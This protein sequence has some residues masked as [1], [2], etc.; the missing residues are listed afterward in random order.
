[1]EQDLAA[2]RADRSAL[3]GHIDA[4]WMQVGGNPSLLE[5]EYGALKSKLDE[6]TGQRSVVAADLLTL[7]GILDQGGALV[8]PEEQA[9]LNEQDQLS[10]QI[11]DYIVQYEYITQDYQAMLQLEQDL[12]AQRD[13]Y[14]SQLTLLNNEN[15]AYLSDVELYQSQL[16]DLAD[17]ELQMQQNLDAIVAQKWDERFAL[18]DVD[19]TQQDME[20][21]VLLLAQTMMVDQG[22]AAFSALADA[23]RGTLAASETRMLELSSELD[24][25]HTEYLTLQQQLETLQ[26][27]APEPT[28]IRIEARGHQLPVIIGDD[29]SNF[30]KFEQEYQQVGV[31]RRYEPSAKDGIRVRQDEFAGYYMYRSESGQLFLRDVKGLSEEDGE[32]VYVEDNA[33]DTFY[34]W[35]VNLEQI[36]ESWYYRDIMGTPD[37]QADDELYEV[38]LGEAVPGAIYPGEVS[39]F[40]RQL[41]GTTT[42]YHTEIRLDE[43]GKQTEVQVPI[44]SDLFTVHDYHYPIII[45]TAD[46]SDPTPFDPAFDWDNVEVYVLDP[47]DMTAA[48]LADIVMVNEGVVWDDA[49]VVGPGETLADAGVEELD[50]EDVLIQFTEF[51][52]NYTRLSSGD[53]TFVDPVAE[54]T[55]KEFQPEEALPSLYTEL[56][57]KGELVA[58]VV[59]SEDGMANLERLSLSSSDSLRIIAPSGITG[60]D[61]GE[62]FTAREVYIES[63][64][65]LHVSGRLVGLDLVSIETSG[66]LYLEPGALVDAQTVQFVS[67]AGSVYGAEGSLVTGETL[68]ADVFGDLSIHSDCAAYD[69]L[70][71]SGDVRIDDNDYDIDGNDWDSAFVP[72]EWDFSE[73]V[74]DLT[75]VAANNGTVTVTTGGT[76]RAHDVAANDITLVARGAGSIELGHIETWASSVSL[77]AARY[78]R[79]IAGT[80]SSVIADEL[81]INAGLDVTVPTQTWPVELL[82]VNSNMSLLIDEFYTGPLQIYE[83]V[84]R[85]IIIDT[86]IDTEAAVFFNAPRNI[87]FTENGGI[88]SSA[89]AMLSAGDALVLST[90]AGTGSGVPT[91][92]PVIHAPDV[93]L[94]ADRIVGGH[95]A[96]ITADMLSATAFEG[97]T[98]RTEA[99]L[100]R[101][102]VLGSGDLTIEALSSVVLDGVAVFDGDLEVTSG[103][104]INA[105]DVV[106]QTD[107][108]ANRLAFSAAGEVLLGGEPTFF[109]APPGG[110]IE[111]PGRI[112][113]FA[114]EPTGEQVIAIRRLNY[115]GGVRL[116]QM[117]EVD[118]QAG[119]GFGEVAEQV[120]VQ[121][122]FLDEFMRAG[123]PT[124]VHLTVLDP[125][126][127]FVPVS[128]GDTVDIE[129]D[130]GDGTPATALSLPYIEPGPVLWDTPS[131]VLG[132]AGGDMDWLLRHD[133]GDG[134]N[135]AVGDVN[136]DGYEDIVLS[137]SFYTNY[138]ADGISRIVLYLGSPGGIADEPA[139]VIESTETYDL[140]TSDIAVAGA[141]DVN[142][143]GYDD[144]LVA[145][146]NQVVEIW[147]PV[148]DLLG[149]VTY[150]QDFV[151]GAL[152]LFAGTPEGLS[153]EPVWSI[154]DLKTSGQFRFS[155]ASAGDVNNDGFD[156]ILVGVP[157]ADVASFDEGGSPVTLSRAG[158]AELY[159]GSADGLGMAP[160]W[161]SQ[162]TQAGGMFGSSVSGIGDL[163]DDGFDDV[164]VGAARENTMDGRVYVFL[165]DGSDLGSFAFQT[166]DGPED[167]W[168][169]WDAI[170]A[171]DVNGDGSPD[172]VVAAPYY[173][174][175]DPYFFRRG[176]VYLYYG[177]SKGF[178]DRPEYVSV[179]EE[180]ITGYFGWD[181][182][183]AGDVNYDGYADFLALAGAPG[184]EGPVGQPFLYLGSADG[185]SPMI[186]RF[187][188][189]TAMT[190]G[191][192]DVPG[193]LGGG[194]F[195]GDG[196]DEVVIGDWARFDMDWA[197]EQPRPGSVA[198]YDGNPLDYPAPV[199]AETDVS[200]TYQTAGTFTLSASVAGA[201]GVLS[202]GGASDTVHGDPV[203]ADDEVVADEDSTLPITSRELLRNDKDPDLGDK[204]T[205]VGLD[206]T[207]MTGELFDDGYGNYLYDPSGRFEY[208][209]PGE[210]AE[211]K[212]E[213][214]ISDQAGGTDTAVVTVVVTGVNDVP[215]AVDDTLSTDEETAITFTAEDLLGNDTDPDSSD[216]LS[217]TDIYSMNT[218]GLVVA[219]DDG[220]YTYDPNGQFEYL[221]PGQVGFDMFEYFITDSHGGT[222]T[223]MVF[224]DIAPVVPVLRS[225][226]LYDDNGLSDS[227]K[228]TNDT[229][230]ILVFEFSDQVFGK[231]SDIVVTD[232]SGR[233][234]VPDVIEGWGSRSLTIV[235]ERALVREGEYSVTLGRGMHD[236]AGNPFNGG[237][238]LGVQFL[239]DLSEPAVTVDRLLTRDV[240]PALTGRVS[241]PAAAVEV[242]VAGATYAATN[243]GAGGWALPAGVVYP[244]LADGIY[245][246][247]ATATDPAGNVG[248]DD[249]TDELTVDTAAPVVTVDFL[250]ADDTTPQLT[251]TVNDLQ[252]TIAVTVND[253]TYWAKN[254]GDGTWVLPDDTIQPPLAIGT[255]DV[256]VVATDPAGNVG[257]DKTTNELRVLSEVPLLRVAS[258]EPS[259]AGFTVGFNYELDLDVLNLYDTLAGEY[260]EPDV[261][262]V[263]ETVG[264]VSGSLVYDAI[265]RT[266]TFV[267][268]GGPLEPDTYTLTLRGAKDGFTDTQGNPLD[269]DR[270]AQ[271]GGDYVT[272]FV[273]EPRLGRLLSVP[274]FTRGPGQAVNVPAAA[275]GIGV[276]IDDGA[277]V[278]AVD[279][280]FEYDPALLDV[281]RLVRGAGMPDDWRVVYNLETPGRIPVTAFGYTPLSAGQMRLVEIGAVIPDDAP[282]AATAVLSLS[283]LQLNGGDIQAQVDSGLEVVAYF[284]DSTGNHSYS[285]LDAA[286]VARLAVGFDTGFAAAYR[287]KDPVLVGDV[288]GNGR[289]SALDAAYIARKAVGFDVPQIPDLP[290][291]LPPIAG[292]GPDP[293]I[294]MPD[295]LTAFRADTLTVPI[296]LAD[297]AG[298]LGGD[299][300]ILYDT[301]VFDVTNSDIQA[302]SLVPAVDGWSVYANV[303]D[304]TGLIQIAVVG[305]NF[306]AGG[307]GAILEMDFNV[308]SDAPVGDTVVSFDEDECE[309]N[310]GELVLSFDR[311]RRR[312]GDNDGGPGARYLG[313]H[314]FGQ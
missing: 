311:G 289:I 60:L 238:D 212:F 294:S 185:V 299:I 274:D 239:L 38:L 202:I 142:G 196:Y 181:L 302:G 54:Y 177:T 18:Y 216:V 50:R 163:N 108:Y 140:L 56:L 87:I 286:Y 2:E 117:V 265:S 194:D 69:V 168:F 52:P 244:E 270:D 13:G 267:K 72:S 28:S 231:D 121:T 68:I 232:P 200:H 182:A 92:T 309:L 199:I 283:E 150:E 308:R 32:L 107:S 85:D 242:T 46:P 154:V 303:N 19:V 213:Y 275:S 264:P 235:F 292:G 278:K 204:L 169:G 279:F 165:G 100:L 14:S 229:T 173:T 88:N 268:T 67:Q 89:G 64:S 78:V 237:A 241:D 25:L 247:I 137:E 225:W 271:P 222:S 151:E 84:Q 146:P 208:L 17:Y 184:G 272:T 39:F 223:A 73:K 29:T 305:V 249:T 191:F 3:L 124:T 201:G 26:S 143:D 195:N 34:T 170:G 83:M 301:G 70:S 291:I 98:L 175:T 215:T 106:I 298:L 136:G 135:V 57:Y 139:M 76:M 8:G 287:L 48:G 55:D 105:R 112:D 297:A 221:Q 21:D 183:P 306:H 258:V 77:D 59:V 248:T 81:S 304:A 266:V 171:G 116:G 211:D 103:G 31:E 129:V 65:D 113:D 243:D 307:S 75:D 193:T 256:E 138:Y 122:E 130:F 277:G 187:P 45:A 214:T 94:G 162:G 91:E 51:T 79:D 71:E 63:Q 153:S 119:S 205:I 219:N 282:Y 27:A 157:A 257:T 49:V 314:A 120:V 134:N 224:I 97:F 86:V 80:Q 263:G 36:G 37:D 284:G 5:R 118:V 128:G 155:A 313:R 255:Y 312:Q 110:V 149:K 132:P 24:L 245:D 123:V 261:T 220:T 251:G 90:R 62:V 10:G 145:A 127:S 74:V 180:F 259:S 253:R 217:V 234:I 16:L 206:T 101:A 281:R 250:D 141:G 198:I 179:P 188:V 11:S 254:I 53:F 126:Y 236:Q 167:G 285:G 210:K 61:F 288:T 152:Y 296:M 104:T 1:L 114:G 66:D 131:L 262:L 260:G 144:V 209:A 218:L 20:A 111:G 252:A 42:E 164:V 178:D 35:M 58:P 233:T 82:N 186:V 125:Y 246:V 148:I 23:Y 40:V 269:G 115:T 190:I 158:R 160:A 156:D 227:D 197:T 102:Q 161:I 44:V 295:D 6:L 9:L 293:L 41:E 4:T 203:A 93:S 12:T 273:V 43:Q 174:Q 109:A 207:G 192:D 147:R 95:D 230:P 7:G 300:D 47:A 15:A 133:M 166:L 290:G 96:L 99:P 276:T 280:V 30:R 176:A 159:L 33:D 172:M 310:E 22:A 228:L 189:G 240:S 226:L